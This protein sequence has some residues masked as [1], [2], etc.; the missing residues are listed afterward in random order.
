MATVDYASTLK[1]AAR[2]SKAG[3]TSAAL[4]LLRKALR[5][6][7]LAPNDVCAAGRL[8]SAEVGRLEGEKRPLRV[9]LLGQL[10]TTWLKQAL[11]ATAWQH[12]QLINVSEG[13]YD[14]VMQEL[15]TS[16]SASER[17]DV[18]VLLPWSA[19]RLDGGVREALEQVEAEAA[20]WRQSLSLVRERLGSRIIMVGYDYIVAGAGGFHLGG[21]N[22]GNVGRI[23]D[24]NAALRRDLP[25]GA[26]FVDLE[27]VSGAMGRETF[28]SSRRYHW[29]KQ[30]FSEAGVVRLAEHIWAGIR[31][32]TTGPKKVLV[33]DL[34]NTLWGGV[35]GE[36]G[37]HGIAL[38]DGADGEAYKAFQSYVRDLNSRGVLL[39]V[40]SKNNAADAREPFTVNREMAL[41][42]KHFAAF[43]ASWE[44]KSVTIARMAKT[45]N[46]GLDSFVFFDDNPVERAEVAHA[47][48]EVSVV[49]V[50]EDPADY[51]S[52][53]HAELWFETTAL[54][55]VDRSRAA[56]YAVERTRRELQ[57]G[58]GS[59]EDYLQSLDLRAE[60]EPIQEG[61]MGRVVQ[62]LAKTNQFNVTTKRHTHDDLL[63]IIQT[64]RSVAI[65]M[66][67]QDKFG[68]YGLVAVILGI[69]LDTDPSTI[70][71]DT[72]LM[73]C[74]VLTRTFEHLMFGE[75]IKRSQALG[76]Q[77]LQGE[78]I[79]SAKNEIVKDLY[80][81]MGCEPVELSSTN[82][83][84]LDFGSSSLPVTWVKHTSEDGNIYGG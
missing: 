50:P 51:V 16:E 52:A 53:L 37:A 77:N 12:S 14:Q 69:P 13:A 30:P 21:S 38:G 65:S 78:Y 22:A 81:T 58:A 32:T 41:N 66:R 54:T 71:V 29:T 62:L 27:Q 49:D 19:H 6:R 4:D 26:Y 7:G 35:V 46:L 79:P 47:L 34:D 9:L 68:D 15:L 48:P 36:T 42:L 72:W 80:L 74:R 8:I 28:Y 25:D 3:E 43:E 39:A 83:Y 67:A 55:D 40:A 82:I 75:L 60:V 17:P 63:R 70:L 23:R 11:T 24:V 64:P 61:D 45:L 31:A 57:E 10:T 56:Q 33:L 2:L 1:I 18:V 76:Y 84:T 5:S 59:M 44:P 20:F 73:S